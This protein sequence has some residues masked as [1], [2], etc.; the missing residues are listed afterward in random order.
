MKTR[1]TKRIERLKSQTN[2][3]REY[4]ERE[5]YVEGRVEK[6]YKTYDMSAQDLRVLTEFRCKMKSI[7]SRAMSV[8]SQKTASLSASRKLLRNTSLTTA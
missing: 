3:K 8:A 7:Q 5:H 2:P 6:L 4:G 1:R